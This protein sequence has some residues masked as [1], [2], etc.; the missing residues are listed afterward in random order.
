MLVLPRTELAR[1]LTGE[2]DRPSPAPS[3]LGHQLPVG[4]L[5]GLSVLVVEDDE[6]AR[7]L[8]VTVLLK[9]GAKVEQAGSMAEA[10]DRLASAVPDVLLSDIGL[11]LDDGYEL[12]RAVRAR[13][14]SGERLPAIA[15]T[16]YARREDQRLALQ[17]G[18]QAHVAKPVEPAELINAVAEA[19]R[20]ARSSARKA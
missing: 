15:L 8:L 10:L 3:H 14:L 1:S 19:A 18:F 9:Q 11:P 17:A 7:D 5:A 16:A 2:S 6:D 13:G 20:A 4:R 12:I